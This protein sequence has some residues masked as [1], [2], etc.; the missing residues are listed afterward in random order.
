VVDDLE[1][2]LFDLQAPE[3]LRQRQQIRVKGA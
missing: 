1:S 3:P 2:P